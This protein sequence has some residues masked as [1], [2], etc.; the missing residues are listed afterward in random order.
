M[1]GALFRKEA[2]EL[3][4]LV[5]VAAIVQLYITA[6]AMHVPLPLLEE[7]DEVVPFLHGGGVISWVLGVAGLLA[8]VVGLRQTLWESTQGTF[9]YLLHT[10]VERDNIFAVKLGVGVATCLL[11]GGLPLAVYALWAATPGTHASP[12]FWSMTVPMW[13]LWVQLPLLYLGA[14]LTG[15]RPARWYGSRLLPILAGAA[16][17]LLVSMVGL[18]S[19]WQLAEVLGLVITVLACAGLAVVVLFV[20][21]TRDFS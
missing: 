1:I 17:Y 10:P 8:V 5:I 13:V 19:D 15:L 12:F 21:R 4:P 7:S 11:V 6:A 3:L 16:T 18:E 2:R 14:F 9:Q 20:A